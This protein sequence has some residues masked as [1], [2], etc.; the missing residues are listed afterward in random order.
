MVVFGTS[1]KINAI[2]IIN[3]G[4]PEN[5]TIGTPEL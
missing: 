5:I 2:K 4:T 1:W 3:I